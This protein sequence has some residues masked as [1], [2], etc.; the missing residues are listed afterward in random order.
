MASPLIGHSLRG[1]SDGAAGAGESKAPAGDSKPQSAFGSVLAR[2]ASRGALVSSVS[3]HKRAGM[4]DSGGAPESSFESLLGPNPPR[5]SRLAAAD[6]WV[7]EL[8]SRNIVERSTALGVAAADVTVRNGDTW[9]PISTQAAKGATKAFPAAPFTVVEKA[10]DAGIEAGAMAALDITATGNTVAYAAAAATARVL[11]DWDLRSVSDKQLG[12][13]PQ[14]ERARARAQALQKN[15]DIALETP[16][17]L[18]DF[19]E[20]VTTM[21]EESQTYRSAL[22]RR[23][24]LEADIDGDGMLDLEEF[25]DLID[26]LAHEYVTGE[27][28]SA[29]GGGPGGDGGGGGDGGDAAPTVM[30]AGARSKPGTASGQGPVRVPGFVSAHLYAECKANCRD[31]V[32]DANALPELLDAYLRPAVRRAVES[33]QLVSTSEAREHLH[34]EDA[35]E[36]VASTAAIAYAPGIGIVGGGGGGGDGMQRRVLAASM[37]AGDALVTQTVRVGKAPRR[38]V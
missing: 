22:V 29:H 23:Q 33:L 3:A 27:V 9:Q 21:W 36:H 19:L 14:T 5:S 31:G 17:Y 24:F 32:I 25:R 37:S 15:A 12:T 10:V 26:R 7:D 6:A 13:F 16:I 1:G 18:V 34:P 11:T 38:D 30:A 8:R 4:D 2:G 35:L 20:I 28:S